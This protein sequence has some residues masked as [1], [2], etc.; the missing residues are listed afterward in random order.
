MRRGLR[1][2]GLA[3]A[4]VWDFDGGMTIRLFWDA[5]L[6]ADPGAPDEVRIV[7]F[8][9]AGDIASLS[10]QGGLEDISETTLQVS[11]TYLDFDE[12]WSGFLAGIGPAGA[13]CVTMADET[14]VAFRDELFRRV[15]SPSGRHRSDRPQPGLNPIC[16]VLAWP[17]RPPRDRQ[18]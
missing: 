3:A 12:L 14:Q 10:E 7:P 13:D 9:S 2:D 8:G 17:A 15:G 4:C 6:T 1:P 18:A 16:P 11:S 5:A